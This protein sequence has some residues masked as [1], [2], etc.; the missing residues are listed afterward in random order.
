MPR[1]EEMF[2]FVVEETPGEEG[3][4]RAALG[5]QWFPLVGADMARI[6]CLLP[7]AEAAC[8]V[9]GRPFRVLK[10]S[11]REDI[12]EQVRRPTGDLAGLPANGGQST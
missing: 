5:T 11:V 8:D 12:T 6:R 10:F 9:D 1:I 3:L 2:A 7:L 4:L